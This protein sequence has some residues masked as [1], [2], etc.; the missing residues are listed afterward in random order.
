[1]TN[2]KAP[3]PKSSSF[4]FVFKIIWGIFLVVLVVLLILESKFWISKQMHNLSFLNDEENSSWTTLINGI[5]KS[6]L[7]TRFVEASGSLESSNIETLGDIKEKIILL[8]KYEEAKSDFETKKLLLEA[9]QLDHQ[10]LKA[11]KLYYQLSDEERQ[12]LDPN[13]EFLIF[14]QSFTQGSSSEYQRLKQ[15]F[16]SSIQQGSLSS[17]AV[18]YYQSAFELAEG[19][20]EKAKNLISSLQSPQYQDYKTS[21]ETAMKQYEGLQDV[22]TYYQDG[23]I[24]LQLMNHGFYGLAKKI[25]LPL[26]SEH[27]NYILPY[28]VL[29]NADLELGR[30]ES[31]LGYFQQLLKLDYQQKNTYL[32]HLWVLSYELGNPSQAVIFFSQITDQNITLDGDR[33]LVLSYLA[34]G[35]EKK[36][37]ISWQ[38]LIGY[39][40]L[41]KSDFYTFFQT[42]F[43][44]PYLQGKKASYLEKD[45]ELV[46][47]FLTLCK[48]RLQKADASVCAYGDLGY[49]ISTGNDKAQYLSQANHFAKQY[50]Q[51]EFYLLLGE[52]FGEKGHIEHA[53]DNFLKAL[54]LATTDEARTHIKSLILK[55]NEEEA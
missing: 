4:P 5:A 33:Y 12:K 35:E 8:E 36:A 15:L 14:L 45:P 19:N 18:N 50:Q 22:P 31:A 7:D 25:A 34:L 49:A 37:L 53:Q 43:W 27:P 1:M 2:K 51:A 21:I 42:A 6:E 40:E 32:Y 46:K 54:K 9:Y 17:E 28:Q 26:V 52:I 10:Y 24:A 39:P 3:T 11:R 30:K 29:A 55:L 13:S 20:Y 44:K 38:R 48:K 47:H 16:S 41:K 23:L